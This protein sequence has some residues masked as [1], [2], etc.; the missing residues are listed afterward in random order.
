[1]V[2]VV[3]DESFSGIDWYGE[4]LADRV[5]RRC[6]FFDVD[7]TE[8]SSR[9]AVLEECR[10]S[11]VKLNASRHV[12]SALLRCVFRRCSLFDAEFTG[13]K[14]MGSSFYECQLRPLT[15]VGG[16]WSFVSL[17]DADLRGVTVRGARMREADLAGANATEA[18]LSDVDLSGAVLRRTNLSRADL[19]GSDLG[20]LDLATAKLAGAVITADQAVTVATLLGFDVR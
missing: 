16:D 10:F 15:V 19:R 11:N 5:Y 6:S 2:E 4:E 12:D 17:A 18:T 1:M 9:G 20:A 3:E 13:C 7:L 14:L 8:S